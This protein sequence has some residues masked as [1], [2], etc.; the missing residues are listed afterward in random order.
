MESKLLNDIDPY[1]Q[2]PPFAQSTEWKERSPSQMDLLQVGC[3]EMCKFGGF[4]WQILGI[5]ANV[6]GSLRREKLMFT[7][8][9]GATAFVGCLLYGT[10][11]FF[12]WYNS[13][14]VLNYTITELDAPEE[15]KILEEPSIKV[16]GRVV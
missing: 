10:I 16:G 7:L 12:E 5:F 6:D 3:M 9:A 4:C 8:A 11:R 1:L 2:Q 14:P 15:K 13:E